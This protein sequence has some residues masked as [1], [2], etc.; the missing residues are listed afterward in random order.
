M[1]PEAAPDHLCCARC[2][3]VLRPG[4]GNFY[5]VTIEAVADPTFSAQGPQAD[6]RHEIEQVLA[7][8]E[9]MSEQ[10][11]LDQVCCRRVLHLCGR[12]YR[13]W[14]ENPTG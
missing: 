4:A 9:G 8:L 3:L 5:R 1:G 10:E 12:C 13:H 7:Q 2:K 11:A 6:V 14:I